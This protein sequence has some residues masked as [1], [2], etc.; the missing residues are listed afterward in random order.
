[1]WQFQTK[2]I[3]KYSDTIINAHSIKTHTY[4][5]GWNAFIIFPEYSIIFLQQICDP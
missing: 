1:M 3:I 2:V 4:F 5:I